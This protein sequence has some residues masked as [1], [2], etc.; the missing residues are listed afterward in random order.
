M[1]Y[2]RRGRDVRRPLLFCA[3]EVRLT[4]RNAELLKCR[5]TRG[6]RPV[7]AQAGGT[8]LD[9]SH[10]RRDARTALELAV[11]ALA[12]AELVDGLAAAAGLLEAVEELPRDSAPVAALVPQLVQRTKKALDKWARWHAEH[13]AKVK[14]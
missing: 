14:A 12:P 9:L 8:D 10:L 1:P 11:V 6:S 3:L 7:G 5:M 2:F 4:A 13:L